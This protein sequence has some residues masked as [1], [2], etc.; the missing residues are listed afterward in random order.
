[1]YWHR[2]SNFHVIPTK[3]WKKFVSDFNIFVVPFLFKK[4][5][6]YTTSKRLFCRIV[7]EVLRSVFSRTHTI[8]VF[9]FWASAEAL[10]MVTVC[11]SETLAPTCKSTRHLNPEEYH[12]HH[13]HRCEN[14]K[15][16]DPNFSF[17]IWK[18]SKVT[19]YW[20]KTQGSGPGK[21]SVSH[22]YVPTG[23]GAHASNGCWG[24][25]GGSV[26][27]TTHLSKY[28]PRRSNP[29]PPS[30]AWCLSTVPTLTFPFRHSVWNT[31]HVSTQCRFQGGL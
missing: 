18:T 28:L 17:I 21:G 10:K 26:K 19:H 27:L 29:P 3:N 12:H 11:F 5:G 24:Q 2:P 14:L 15:P 22:H 23:C 9:M 25:S 16:H 31:G 4:S 8:L 6:S 13:P 1:M 20:L 30:G 7:L